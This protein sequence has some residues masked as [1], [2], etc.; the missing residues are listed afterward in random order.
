VA[1]PDPVPTTASLTPLQRLEW[2]EQTLDLL[3]DTEALAADR[4]RRRLA[5][6]R[7][8]SEHEPDGEH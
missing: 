1:E 7:W 8:W 4:E 6:A 2:L 5:A 3:R